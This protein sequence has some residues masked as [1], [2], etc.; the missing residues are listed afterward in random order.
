MS[1][2]FWAVVGLT[3]AGAAGYWQWVRSAGPADV[4]VRW[5]T[6]DPG[7][8]WIYVGGAADRG[9]FYPYAL[10]V[11]T[12]TGRWAAPDRD[13][14]GPMLGMLFSADGRY[15]ALLGTDG[16]GTAV[17]LTDFAVSPP[18]VSRVSLE[19]SPPPGWATAFAL[20]PAADLAF[21]AHETGASIFALPTGRR[22]A[23]T[24]IP[25]G[26]RPAVVRFV[27]EGATRTWLVPSSVARRQPQMRV[28][29][30]AADGRT[31]TGVF[32]LTGGGDSQ[33]WRPL[34]AEPAGRRIVTFDAGAHLRDGTTGTM[35]AT[36]AASRRKVEVSLLSDGRVVVAEPHLASEST[37]RSDTLLRVFDGDGAPLS[38]VPLDLRPMGLSL[39]PETAPGRLLVSSYQA[40]FVDD[41]TLLVDVASG[42]VVERLRG[43]R[44]ATESWIALWSPS[45]TGPASVQFFGD[46]AGRLIR[47]DFTTGAR[48]IVAG[49]DAPR[50]ERIGVRW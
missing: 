50:G 16:R 9:G 13:E 1:F 29:D 6:R 33:T 37:T 7:G 12:R 23:T 31:A 44:P 10:L 4:R 3:L 21:T 32:P 26:W 19:S 46:A 28:V 11:D 30:L 17:A 40:P 15:G 5:L 34:I 42:Q 48:T 38:E 2:V 41:E 24:T 22:V 39:G 14:A 20:S 47:I 49:P 43:L 36:L 27:G 18:R 45:A 35:L 25:S 8:R